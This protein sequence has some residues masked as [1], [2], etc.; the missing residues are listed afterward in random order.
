MQVFLI[1]IFLIQYK[2]NGRIPSTSHKQHLLIISLP[3]NTV[4]RLPVP[5][6]PGLSLQQCVLQSVLSSLESSTMCPPV[7]PFLIRTAF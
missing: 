5:A 3:S 4:V 1:P 7:C 6:H 2:P